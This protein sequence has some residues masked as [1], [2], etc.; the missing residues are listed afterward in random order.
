MNLV[1]AFDLIF[2]GF[3][4]SLL[5]SN[6]HTAHELIKMISFVCNLSA[7]FL[8][9]YQKPLIGQVFKFLPFFP[10]WS[11][12]LINNLQD[13]GGLRK[14][15][16]GSDSEIYSFR[17]WNV[18]SLLMQLG[19]YP[20]LFYYLKH[21]IRNEKDN[22]Q[23][24][25]FFLRRSSKNT[26]RVLDDTSHHMSLRTLIKERANRN[27]KCSLTRPRLGPRL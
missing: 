23:T 1:F 21:T 2:F 3:I 10:Y 15:D 11:F 13:K 5:F 26:S 6:P 25:F 7:I 19:L 4:I 18:I 24:W 17:N 9:L 12:V 16:P 20:L 27:S 22:R 8:N 14:A